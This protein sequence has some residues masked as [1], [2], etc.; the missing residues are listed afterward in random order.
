MTG[1]G[2]DDGVNGRGFIDSLL[3]GYGHDDGVI[4]VDFSYFHV[5]ERGVCHSIAILQYCCELYSYIA[6]FCLDIFMSWSVVY[7][8]L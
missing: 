4:G 6:I 1:Y 7:A 8:I 5:L 2:H 3:S